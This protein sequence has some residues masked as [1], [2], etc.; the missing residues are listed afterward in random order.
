MKKGL[1]IIFAGPSGVGKGTVLK[2]LI[3]DKELNLVYSVSMTTRA[4]REGEINGVSYFFV[5]KAEFERAIE[6]SELLEYACYVDNYYG[7]PK[8]YVEQKRNEGFNVI[9]EIETVGA[10]KVMGMYKGDVTSIYLVPPDMEE[11]E[12]RLR[13]RGTESEDKISKRIETARTELKKL[14]KFKY[15]VVNDDINETV[16]KVKE[17]ILKEMNISA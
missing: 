5:D 12:H 11:L 15:V 4:P 10:E 6:N 1:L 16:K 14:D 8:K 3:N 13:G 2:E 7:T 9:L 17:I